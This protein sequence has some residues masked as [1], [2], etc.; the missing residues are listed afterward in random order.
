MEVAYVRAKRRVNREELYFNFSDYQCE[1]SLEG[2]KQFALWVAQGIYPEKPHPYFSC[3]KHGKSMFDI[4]YTMYRKMY[5]TD[6]WWGWYA[7][8]EDFKDEPWL[9]PYLFKW[10]GRY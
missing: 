7:I 8:E 3:L 4:T 6:D 9:L 1:P 5:L 2:R 10:S